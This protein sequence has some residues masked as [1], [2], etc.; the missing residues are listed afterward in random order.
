[1]K[2]NVIG[3]SA[4]LASRNLERIEN[5]Q[6][7]KVEVINVP[8][9]ATFNI[10]SDTT[11]ETYEVSSET[12][13]VDFYSFKN[14]KYQVTVIWSTSENDKTINHEAFGNPLLIS[15]DEKGRYIIPAPLATAS[16][17]EILYQALADILDVLLPLADNVKNGADVI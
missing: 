6:L 17:L 5:D 8:E 7:T 1:M 16:E 10:I 2:Y 15:E 13:K 4:I 11:T 14:G 9:G 3:K 12:T